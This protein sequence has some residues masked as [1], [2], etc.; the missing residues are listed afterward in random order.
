[1]SPPP[2]PGSPEPDAEQPDRYPGV[3]QLDA[4]LGVG[5]ARHDGC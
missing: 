4:D 2:E 5:C 1:M 3:V